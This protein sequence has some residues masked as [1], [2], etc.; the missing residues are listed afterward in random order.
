MKRKTQT[1]EPLRKLQIVERTLIKKIEAD[2]DAV[3]P[4]LKQIEINEEKL[5]MFQ[6][7]IS[8]LQKMIKMRDD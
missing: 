6:R 2:R 5:R 8:E 7:A 1:Y 4:L 3:A